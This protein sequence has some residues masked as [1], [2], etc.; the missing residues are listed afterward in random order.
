MTAQAPDII[1]FNGGEHFVFDDPL[2]R[3]VGLPNFMAVSTANH[4]GYVAVWAI[5]GGRL[6]LVSLNGCLPFDN[7]N[8]LELVFPSAQAPVLA[9]WYS[10]ELRLVSGRVI[11]QSDF[12]PIHEREEVLT[13]EGGHIRSQRSLSR[14]YAPAQHFDPIL[15]Q[16]IGCLEELG[17]ELLSRL[18]AAN[19]C[20]VGDLIQLGELELAKAAGLTVDAA[21]N[22]KDALADRGLA[23]GNRSIDWPPK[24]ALAPV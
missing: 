9:D 2:S 14:D 16:M 18:E 15:F 13:V 3:L 24:A 23:L 12:E 10:G 19:F 1:F 8:G 6:Y 11:S 20:R 7:R 17:P 21:L 22:V 5:V 4:R